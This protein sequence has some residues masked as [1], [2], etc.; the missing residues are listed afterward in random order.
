MLSERKPISSVGTLDREQATPASNPRQ[1]LLF[2]SV[3]P[4]PSPALMLCTGV[5]VSQLNSSTYVPRPTECAM[6]I[7]EWDPLEAAPLDHPCPKKGGP[8]TIQLSS[9]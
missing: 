7:L 9:E 2:F 4:S 6:E 3:S 1:V 5:P 8:G